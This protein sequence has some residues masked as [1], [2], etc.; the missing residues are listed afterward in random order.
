MLVNVMDFSLCRGSNVCGPLLALAVL[1]L[2][3]WNPPSS[4]VSVCSLVNNLKVISFKDTN[5]QILLVSKIMPKNC[6]VFIQRRQRNA[7]G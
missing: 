3:E 7:G 4:T 1:W 6:E 5:T 2:R